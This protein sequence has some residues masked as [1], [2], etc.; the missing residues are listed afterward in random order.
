ML[1]YSIYTLIYHN[2]QGEIYKIC[3]A[4]NA[5][6]IVR[7]TLSKKKKRKQP[8]LINTSCIFMQIH[9]F[10]NIINFLPDYVFRAFF[11]LPTS[12]KCVKVRSVLIKQSNA[13]QSTRFTHGN[14]LHTQP[15]IRHP[16]QSF[17]G[18][19]EILPYVRSAFT[20]PTYV[21]LESPVPVKL[22]RRKISRRY[23]EDR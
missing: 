4:V 15:V 11:Y 20:I 3:V 18:N 9:I 6:N 22:P 7:S 1:T 2:S 13:K 12:S 10:L 8:Q 21:L 16:I 17:T 14:Q 23:F 5:L 19:L